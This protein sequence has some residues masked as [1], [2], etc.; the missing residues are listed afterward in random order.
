MH[1]HSA[2]I[3]NISPPRGLPSNMQEVAPASDKSVCNKVQ[4]Q[5]G[6]ICVTNT[7]PPGLGSRCTQPAMEGSGPI[8]LPTSSHCGQSDG[9]VVA[10]PIQIYL[11]VVLR[12]VQQPGSYCDG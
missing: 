4:Q 5:T 6:P 3:C 7:K 12:H 10:L 11:F 2:H 1:R 8:C 9:E